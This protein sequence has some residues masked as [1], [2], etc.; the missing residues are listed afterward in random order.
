MDDYDLYD[1]DM[2]MYERRALQEDARIDAESEKRE[3]KTVDFEELVKIIADA[4]YTARSYS[5]RGMYGNECLGVSCDSP[6]E[7]RMDVLDSV[8]GTDDYA[9]VSRVMRGMRTDSLGRRYIAYFPGVEWE[10]DRGDDGD[11]DDMIDEIENSDED[12]F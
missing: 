1:D 8:E 7:F 4:G 9:E 12:I 3:R 5:G 10:E 11:F 2:E 6:E